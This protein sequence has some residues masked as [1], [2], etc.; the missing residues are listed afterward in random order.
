MVAALV[1]LNVDVIVTQG[2]AVLSAIRLAGT[3]PVVMG[4]S[5]DAVEAKFVESLARPG[6]TRTGVTFLALQ[7]VDKRLEILAPLLPPRARIAVIADPQ[8]CVDARRR[9]FHQRNGYTC[10]RTRRPIRAVPDRTREAPV[11]DPVDALILDLLDWIGPQSRPYAE[12]M[13]AWRTSCPRL[14]V[15]EEANARGY[16]IREHSHR[17]GARISLSPLGLAALE[18]R[19]RA[20]A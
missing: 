16:I 3:T 18:Q 14:P 13:D 9:R 20:V 7:L 1:Q 2:G 15:W 10:R 8:A 19:R 12:V 17:T 11:S 5:G 6:G 4:Y